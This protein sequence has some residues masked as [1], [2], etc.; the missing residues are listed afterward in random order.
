[1]GN[2][3]EGSLQVCMRKCSENVDGKM[4]MKLKAHGKI[5]I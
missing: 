4:A 1:M 3:L 5:V 2:F